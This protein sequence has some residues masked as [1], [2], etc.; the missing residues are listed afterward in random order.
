[1]TGI[2]APVRA[3][4]VVVVVKERAAPRQVVVA[5]GELARVSAVGSLSVRLA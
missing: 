1:M 4:V 3:A 2:I 5:A